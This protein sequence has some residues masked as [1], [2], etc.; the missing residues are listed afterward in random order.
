MQ[1][2]SQIVDRRKTK[3]TENPVLVVNY[4]YTDARVEL[5]GIS[6]K[7]LRVKYLEKFYTYTH[8]I[9]EKTTGLTMQ[10]I[11][12]KVVDSADSDMWIS[13]IDTSHDSITLTVYIACKGIAESRTVTMTLACFEFKH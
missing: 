4:P 7:I 3:G 12:E 9:G 8:M 13:Q 10:E 1:T 11:L 6:H 2:E 5:T